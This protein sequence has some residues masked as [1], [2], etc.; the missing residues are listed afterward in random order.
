MASKSRKRGNQTTKRPKTPAV[1]GLTQ[2]E[3]ADRLGVSVRWLRDLTKAEEI[4]CERQGRTLRYLWP[5]VRDWYNT[6]LNQIAREKYEPSD[7]KEERAGL[8]RV[9]RHLAELDFQKK[10]GKLVEVDT[11]AEEIK[12]VTSFLR[13]RLLNLPGRL[14]PELVGLKTISEA[15]A[16]V[17]REVRET[18][19]EIVGD[20]DNLIEERPSRRKAK[21]SRS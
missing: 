6:Y 18:L 20:A 8:V 1:S 14:G 4:P 10:E 15:V 21:K 5:G 16:I 7:L 2:K 13:G 11:A 9:Q 12:R 19:S 3:T 17:D